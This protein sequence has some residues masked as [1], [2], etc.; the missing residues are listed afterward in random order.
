MSK[1]EITDVD[2]GWERS[3][4]RN[5]ICPVEE[6]VEDICGIIDFL[7]A[8]DGLDGEG[9]KDYGGEENSHRVVCFAF[10]NVGSNGLFCYFFRRRSSLYRRF[11]P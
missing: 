5:F 8:G 4:R 3:R 1:S 6:R 11:V 2:V 9:T 10:C 7:Y